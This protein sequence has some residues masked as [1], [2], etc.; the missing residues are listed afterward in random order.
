[1]SEKLCVF[2]IHFGFSN[3][4]YGDYAEGASGECAKGHYRAYSANVYDEES[5]R[6]IIVV[7]QSCN[8]YE[9][10]KT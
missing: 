1:M 6:K 2:C 9:Q 10:V 7:A 5:L 8:D 3:D 4:M